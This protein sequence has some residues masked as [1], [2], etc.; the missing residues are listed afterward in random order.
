[1]IR[2]CAQGERIVGHTR[3][4]ADTAR[5]SVDLPAL[6]SPSSPT[7]AMT[8]I[9][10]FSIRFSPGR[11]DPNWRGAR[12]VLL[13]NLRVAH[14]ALAALGHLQRLARDLQI[15]AAARRSRNPSRVVPTG[16]S[17]YRS[18]PLRPV[19]SLPEPPSPFFAL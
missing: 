6:G 7:S 3:Q 19:Q 13:L 5:I 4:A 2:R 10:K 16:T 18:S 9:S 11:P 8:F 14:A 1:M 15:A 12:L 17:T